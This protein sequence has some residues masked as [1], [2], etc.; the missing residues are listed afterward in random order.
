[1]VYSWIWAIL[2]AS[3]TR[4]KKKMTRCF[5]GDME[6][7]TS[8]NELFITKPQPSFWVSSH[9][10]M[11]PFSSSFLVLEQ[12][13]LTH[14]RSHQTNWVNSLS[15]MTILH[16]HHRNLRAWRPSYSSFRWIYHL[17]LTFW[18]NSFFI[19]VILAQIMSLRILVIIRISSFNLHLSL[20]LRLCCWPFLVSFCLF[21][22]FNPFL[23]FDLFLSLLSLLCQSCL[24]SSTEF[25]FFI[26]PFCLLSSK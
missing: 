19:L 23:V 5:G 17:S 26:P 13:L 15:C 1:M 4:R 7:P 25:H 11:N 14:L 24:T 6:V 21:L 22:V 3:N 20:H 18:G 12:W 10:L 8:K 16:R 9:L 2:W